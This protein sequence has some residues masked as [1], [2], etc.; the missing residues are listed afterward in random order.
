MN[1]IVSTVAIMSG[2]T[3]L[4]AFFLTLA[5]RTVGD[6]GMVDITINGKKKL[7]VRGG[8]TLLLAL[9]SEKIFI[10]S[11]CGGKGTCG[12]C[13][14][15]VIEGGGAILPMEE[16]L[17][18][19]EEIG[20]GVRLACQ[21]KVK[22]AIKIEIPE[23]LFNVR[24]YKAVVRKIDEITPKIK[25][26]VLD[27]VE[28]GEINFKPGQ[29][30]QLVAPPYAESDESV[31][32]AY[33]IAS[34]PTDKGFI[35]LIIGY[36]EGGVCTTYIHKYLKEGDSVSFNGPFGNFFYKDNDRE[37]IMVAAGT[38]M[39]PIL[40]ILRAMRSSGIER[41]C[42]FFF[43]AKTRDDL[44]FMDK[45][46]NLEESL[47][48]FE[49]VPALSRIGPDDDWEGARGRVTEPLLKHLDHVENKEAYL[50]GSPVMI[51]AIVKL[52][53]EKGM[54]EEHIYYDKF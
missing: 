15:K 37:M 2:I 47:F 18:S 53:I 16:G 3:G 13:K 27:I 50:C 5:K 26:L 10:P 46:Q 19:A 33:S 41:R 14:L 52:L 38:G 23:D 51:D 30:V 20:E 54:N 22:E 43:G 29:Y 40:S 49:F 9:S 17:I 31:Q 35:E 21:I 36:V 28:G 4:L 42:S 25:H 6:Y 7:E 32:R 45:M 39:A 48:D 1:D 34:C 8:D 12:Y 11:A 44:F 24:E